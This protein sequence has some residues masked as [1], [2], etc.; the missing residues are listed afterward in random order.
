MRTYVHDHHQYN[1]LCSSG[2]AVAVNN[3][4]WAVVVAVNVLITVTV[5]VNAIVV[6]VVFVLSTVRTAVVNDLV[7]LPPCPCC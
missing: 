1:H 3:N 7:L 2:G 6:L 5:A 4:S